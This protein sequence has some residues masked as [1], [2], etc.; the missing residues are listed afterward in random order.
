VVAEAIAKDL[1]H[2]SDIGGVAVD[3]RNRGEVIEAFYNI[4]K[5][6][7]DNLP[8]AFNAV[9]IQKMI[10]NGK[11]VILGMTLMPQFGP[12]LMFGLG[13]I[14]VEIIKDVQFRSVPVSDLEAEEMITSI[15]GFPI[16]KGVRGEKGV[17]VDIIK[18]SLQRLSQLVSDFENISAIDINPL[19]VGDKKSSS[20]IVDARIQAGKL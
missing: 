17:N 4:K 8:N 14:F 7:N 19:K 2:K 1:V 15:K 16:L 13:G 3:L 11:E 9:R 12:L 5:K 18:E 10:Q 6:V 20:L